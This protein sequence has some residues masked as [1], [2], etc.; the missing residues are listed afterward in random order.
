MTVTAEIS[1]TAHKESLSAS[2]VS[3]LTEA[4][5]DA[6]TVTLTLTGAVYEG[7]ISK[8][9][10]AV[11]VSGITGV[12]VNTSQVRRLS[13]RR[14]SVQLDYDGTD[15]DTDSS[16]TFTIISE[17][18]A[19]HNGNKLTTEI[20]VTAIVEAVAASVVSP[21]TEETLD[22]SIVTLTLTG[23]VYE[24]DLS[25]IRD[26]VT[27]SGINGVTVDTTIVQRLGDTIVAIELDYDDTDFFRDAAM[28][29]NVAADAITNYIGNA[30]ITELPVTASRNESLL[31]IFWT[32]SGTDKIQRA[33][34]DGS[35]VEDLVTRT[36]GLETPNGIALDVEAGKMYWTDGNTNKI[37]RANLDGSNIEDLVTRTQ[38]L[39]TPN[40][41]ALD[42][43]AGKMYWT[44][45]NTDKIQRAN[46]DGSN[47]E[48]LVIRTQGLWWPNDIA[49]DVAAGKMYW[50]D[51]DT[52]KI[53]RANLDGSNIEDL[54]TQGLEWPK[55]IA[56]DVAA[57]KM[58]WTDG[59]TDK[60]QRANLD[61]SNIE[62]LVTQGLWWPSGIALDVAAGKM[63]WTDYG[64]DKIQRAN[65]DGS[66]IEDLVTQ[67]LRDP[68]GIALGIF[69]PVNPITETEE[70]T[71]TKEDVNGDGVVDVNDLVIVAQQY[72][73]TGTNDADVNGDEIV[74]VDDFILV[75][76]AV[77][78]AAAA[79]PAARA[80]V[81]SHFTAAQLQGW[82]TEARA[83]GDTS[84]IYQR[85]IAVVEQLLAMFAPKETALF[86]NYPNPFN[87]ET[88]IPYQLSKSADVTLTIYDIQ[89]RVV[90]SLDLGHQRAG[91]Y[92]T[93]PRAAY[94]DGRNA[95]GEL[96]ASGLYFYT[97][98]AGDFTAT[99]KMLIRK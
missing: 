48:D 80:Q 69:S 7:D 54:V 3:P 66:N 22:G 13:D 38:G 82:L 44:D 95:Q 47:I 75:A 97:L 40:G 25:N 84:H 42:V 24:Q 21:L 14:V 10:D 63:Y 96:V 81:Q 45:G 67:G 23:S 91:M 62:D 34:L 15:F 9:R 30:L 59:G 71:I 61:G 17:A 93:R 90:R 83:S 35:N 55:G 85:G 99:R 31:M 73:K 92:Q 4:T 77:D 26:S 2:V 51:G 98:T 36:Q 1:V 89:G 6:G 65:L 72:G 37:Q 8:I 33:N 79:A 70:P 16:L 60:I 50:T 19:N 18:I 43:E 76:A 87:P 46:L 32:D 11:T 74:N 28:I 64:T 88:W 68:N 52:D 39:E 29:F 53:H 41:I 86:P 49:L 94:W 20:P 27:V 58:Y 78:T 57:G 5:L 56:L 12:T